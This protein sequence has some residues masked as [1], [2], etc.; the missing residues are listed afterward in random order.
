MMVYH[1]NIPAGPGRYFSARGLSKNGSKNYPQIQ[2]SVYTN[3]HGNR[4]NSVEV[5]ALQWHQVK[6]KSDKLMMNG[7]LTD[8]TAKIFSEF[9]Y[10]HK[11]T[12]MAIG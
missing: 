6:W 3:I 10:L 1:R 2:I 11:Q 5:N 8:D 9:K 4:L 7:E 12:F